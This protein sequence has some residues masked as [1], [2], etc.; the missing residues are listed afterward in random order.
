MLLRAAEGLRKRGVPSR[1]IARALTRLS[2]QLPAGRPLSAVHIEARGDEVLVRDADTVWAPETEQVAFDFSVGELASRVAPFAAR[3]AREREAAGEMDA[4]DWYDLGFDLEAVSIEEAHRAY[5]QALMLD[6]G[7]PDALVNAGRLLHE[8]GHVPEAERRYR[9]ALRADPDHTLARFNLG[10]ALDDG[11]RHEE[12]V[13]AYR[14]AL[15]LDPGLSAAHFNLARLLEASGDLTGAV[16]HLAA[17][18]ALRDSE[19]RARG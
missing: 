8:A 12:A 15:D 3:V 14:G 2:R 18:K 1:R 7:H 17:Y 10:V 5:D 4:D 19:R 11:G 16:R 13:E 6:P 9:E